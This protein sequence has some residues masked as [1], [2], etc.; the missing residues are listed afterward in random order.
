MA[1]PNCNSD[2]VWDDVSAW[3]CNKCGWCSLQGLNRTPTASYPH[4]KHDV[5]ERR[6]T[7]GYKEQKE[8]EER[9]KGKPIH[10]KKSDDDDDN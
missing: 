7:W 3:G 6:R 4:S 9:M 8:Y 10:V 5:A 2:D 1:C